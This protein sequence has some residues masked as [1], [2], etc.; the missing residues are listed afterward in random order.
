M[1]KNARQ[2]AFG[3]AS[4]GAKTTDMEKYQRKAVEEGTGIKCPKTT[5]R[6]NSRKNT[7][8]DL[9][10][11]LGREDGFDYTEDFD[12][13]QETPFAAI[14]ISFKSVVGAGG[15]QTR[16][17]RECYHFAEAQL[18]FMVSHKKKIFF[19]NILDGDE[20]D[21]RMKHFKH[22][23]ALPEYAHIAHKVY[24]GHLGGYFDWVN[25]CATIE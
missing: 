8:E 5:Y 21:K 10:Q 16:T 2:E 9:S 11:P 14:F 7:L 25:K 4:G 17:L 22:L 3:V 15:S 20:A 23:L 1:T 18:K 19:A 12:G 24:V 6:I 13:V